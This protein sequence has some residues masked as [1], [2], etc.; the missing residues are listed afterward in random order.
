[1]ENKL[2]PR[3]SPNLDGVGAI[4]SFTCAAHCLVLPLLLVALPWLGMSFLVDRKMEFFFIC[5]SMLLATLSYCSGY[6]IH[7]KFRLLLILYL[8]TGMIVAGKILIGGSMGLW[9]AV[10][11]AVGLAAGHLLNRKLCEHCA[12]CGHLQVNAK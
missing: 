2:E 8:C 4:L 6:Y 9:L 10:P 3:Y 7:R 5:G 12:E 1:M 11:G